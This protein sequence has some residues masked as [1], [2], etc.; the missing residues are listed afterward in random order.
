[1]PEL[2]EVEV[3]KRYLAPLVKGKKIASVEVRRDKVITPTSRDALTQ[4]LTGARFSHIERRG[5]YLLFE[6]CKNRKSVTVL[7]HLGM[8]GRM[9]LQDEKAPLAKHAAV[10]LHLGTC[11]FV[12]E[13]PRYFG[14]FTLDTSPVNSLGPEPL[15]KDFTPTAFTEKLRR[16]SQAIKIK[17]L[18]QSLVA[19]IGNIYASEALYR[20]HLSPRRAARRLTREEIQRL[21]RCIRAVLSEAIHWGSTIPLGFDG[22]G[23]ADGLF[24]FGTASDAPQYYH[25][26]LRVYDRAS[27]PCEQC[28]EKIKRLTQAARSTYYCPQC[29]K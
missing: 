17:L 11:R 1:M 12:Y 21:W 6:F 13:D 10:I 8:T 29:Q 16:S 23:K 14:R 5:K 7:G 25:E 3:L 27:Q 9:Y 15:S 18:N 20:A 28:G 22:S 24:Y 26:R 2:P 4:V 19:G